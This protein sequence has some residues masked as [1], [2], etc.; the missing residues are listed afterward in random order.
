MLVLGIALSAFADDPAP[1]PLPENPKAV[2]LSWEEVPA[3]AQ[4]QKQTVISVRSDGSV[5]VLGRESDPTVR[6]STQELQALLAFVIEEQRFFDVDREAL[7]QSLRAAKDAGKLRML[8]HAPSSVLRVATAKRQKVVRVS[9]LY[10]AS[11]QLHGDP[12]LARLMAVRNRLSDL[13]NEFKSRDRDARYTREQTPQ[14]R[15]H[16]R[17]VEAAAREHLKDKE[18]TALGAVVP[19]HHEKLTERL[20]HLRLFVVEWIRR[21][22]RDYLQFGR[23]KQ[24]VIHHHS[25]G[26]AVLNE[27]NDS[28][29]VHDRGMKFATL[30]PDFDLVARTEDEARKL[31]F[32]HRLLQ[33]LAAGTIVAGTGQKWHLD[34]E[35]LWK[36]LEVRPEDYEQLDMPLRIVRGKTRFHCVRWALFADDFGMPKHLHFFIVWFEIGGTQFQALREKLESPVFDRGARL[37]DEPVREAVEAFLKKRAGS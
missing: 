26:L 30:W 12:V 9:G 10:L 18:D 7:N 37:E 8:P 17:R 23:K 16:V 4:G 31:F 34:P 2:V 32:L 19:V 29:R 1:I 22:V 14:E 11:V 13:S 35:T 3:R 6:L 27:T 5:S 28:L 25:Y 36:T 20:P 21:E 15:E 33:R 24:Q